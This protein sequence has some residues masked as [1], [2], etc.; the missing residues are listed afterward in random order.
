MNPE[1]DLQGIL[2]NVIIGGGVFSLLIYIIAST[3]NK[4]GKMK[5]ILKSEMEKL[6]A[7]SQDALLD[8]IDQQPET[9]LTK[10]NR[11]YKRTLE[12]MVYDKDYYVAKVRVLISHPTKEQLRE[13]DILV[14]NFGRPPE[15]EKG[16]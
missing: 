7:L 13:E 10:D 2:V 11:Q 16:T 8:M 3:R 15:R 5:D 12:L 4:T 1:I 14:K 9:M 6:D